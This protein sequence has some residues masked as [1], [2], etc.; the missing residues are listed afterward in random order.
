M[1]VMTLAAKLTLNTAEFDS[2]LTSSEKKMKGMTSGGVAWG[3]I[4]SD[5]VKKAANTAK[6]LATDFV[7]VGMNFDAAMSQVQALGQLGEEDFQK[8]RKKAMELGASTKFTAAQVAEGFSY[9]ALAGWKTDDMLNGIDGMLRLAAASGEDLG[10]TSDIITDALTAFGLTAEDTGHFV[11]VLAAASANSNTTVSMMGQA[12]KYL[13]ANAGVLNYSIDDVAVAL[14]LLANNGI[15]SSQAGTSMRQILN[16]LIAPT[17]DAAEAMQALGISLFEAGTD[18]VKPLGQVLVEMREI[19]K[20]ANF[21]LS[22]TTIDKIQPQ[23]DELDKWYDEWTEKIKNSVNGKANYLDQNISQNDLDEMYETKLKEITNFNEVFLGRLKDIGGLRGVSSLIALMKTTD[24]D[25]EK[26]TSAVENSQGSSAEMADTMLNN[27][28][29]DITILN[30]ALE[31]LKIVVSDSFKGELREFIQMLT[32]QVG[33]LNETFQQSGALGM[34]VNLA[35]WVINGIANA[36]SNASAT[37]EAASEF[38]TAIGDFVGRTIGNLVEKAPDLIAGLFAA[39]VGLAEGLVNGL[40]SGLFG[41][42]EGTVNGIITRVGEKEQDAIDAANATATKATGI[43]DYMDS[44]VEKYGDAAKNTEAWNTALEKLKEV[45]PQINEFIKTQGGE[46][47]LANENL[48]KYIENTKAMMI[49]DAK[50]AALQSY[51][52]RY[53]EAV[54]NQGMAEINAQIASSQ[55]EEARNG[56]IA[57]IAGHKGQE[58]FTGEGLTMQQLEY[59][60]K[61]VANEFGE[62]QDEIN[63]LTKI[64][65]EQT[66]K[67]AEETAK[68]AEL[69]LSTQLLKEQMDIAERALANLTSA[70]NSFGNSSGGYTTYGEWAT[71]YYTRQAQGNAKGLWD[72]PYD[73]YLTRLH[74]GEMVLN[75]SR[76]RDY[77]EGNGTGLDMNALVAG[78]VGAIRQGMSGAEVNSYLDGRGVTGDVNR[79]TLNQIK[80]RRFAT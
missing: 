38:G 26:L 22:G 15:K 66:K 32:E 75:A 24:E 28:T 50:K 73:D 30:S 55:A 40:F 6:T 34:F 68:I 42:G 48:V 57:Y 3:N 16:S 35:D 49:E 65:D 7:Q 54:Q 4:I 13:A 20:N 19:F 52:D 11:D 60:A 67:A 58:G 45:Y 63:N 62:S 17:D 78:V 69:E 21:D 76:A 44:L 10:T 12:F 47:S 25:Y 56:L 23:I 14:G 79:R 77:R 8:L 2:N 61:A 39:G 80:A 36:L 46:L 29:G 64:Y 51:V 71:Q 41:T 5:V 37:G 70:A 72:V 9:M 31:G 1:D 53:T 33:S 74:R 27:L 18:K 43:I 59:A